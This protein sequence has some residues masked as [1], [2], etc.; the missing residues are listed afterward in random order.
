MD[1]AEGLLEGEPERTG[2]QLKRRIVLM[3]HE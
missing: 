3:M 2:G 1:L